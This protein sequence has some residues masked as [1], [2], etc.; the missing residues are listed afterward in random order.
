VTLADLLAAGL[1]DLDERISPL[2]SS[3]P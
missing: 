3:V 2:E 1:V